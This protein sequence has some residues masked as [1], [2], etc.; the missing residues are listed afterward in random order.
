MKNKKTIPSRTGWTGPLG[1]PNRPLTLSLYD[2]RVPPWPLLS[3][4]AA[5]SP[6][7]RC[8]PAPR[9]QSAEPPWLPIPAEP[10]ALVPLH[11]PASE[12]AE[13]LP[14]PLSPTSS[15]HYWRNDRHYGHWWPPAPL[16]LP[17]AP[18]L[19]YKMASHPPAPPL[20]NSPKLSLFSLPAQAGNRHSDRALA[21]APT[22][23]SHRAPASP[24]QTVRA[25]VR[26]S[27]SPRSRPSQPS[28][29]VEPLSATV[30][31][32]SSSDRPS[33]CPD[34]PPSRL[35]LEPPRR[36]PS[37]HRRPSQGWRQPKNNFIN[38]LNHVLN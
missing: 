32:S 13:S 11:L 37:T 7:P 16:P 35:S 20:P 28:R 34:R 1:K 26:A 33:P 10:L 5:P 31:R 18:S 38:F 27:S 36:T 25:P 8:A 6:C 17:S 24:R 21:G 3:P 23:R 29:H 14:L 2:T 15:L 9:I 12:T 19:L 30:T 4:P 22:P